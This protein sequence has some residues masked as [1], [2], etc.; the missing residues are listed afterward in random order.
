MTNVPVIEAFDH[1]HVFVADRRAAESWYGRVLGFER[2][3]ALE[4]WAAGG[5]PLTLQNESGTVHIALFERAPQACRSTLALRVTGAEYLKWRAHLNAVLAGQVS[6]ED[7][8]MSLSLYFADPDGN[9]Y[10][11]TTYEHAQVQRS[12]HGRGDNGAA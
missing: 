10:E 7:H 4:S 5:G 8:E 9:P 3:K 1:I 11:I 6:E 2:T 12:D